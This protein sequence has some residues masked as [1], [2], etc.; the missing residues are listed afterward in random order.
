MTGCRRNFA[1]DERR[2]EDS[3]SAVQQLGVAVE[4]FT[5][6]LQSEVVR[7]SDSVE[8]PNQ[9]AAHQTC[10]GR[11]SL[12]SSEYLVTTYSFCQ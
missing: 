12:R 7:Q 5:R 10:K 3:R 1:V 8:H 2:I 11:H 6:R 9:I 4:Q